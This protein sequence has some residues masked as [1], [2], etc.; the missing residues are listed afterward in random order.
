MADKK[1]NH[2][3]QIDNELY[4]VTAER[5]ANKLI[6]NTVKDGVVTKAG[7]FDG[8][9]QTEVTLAVGDAEAA[10]HADKIQVTMANNVQKYA[11]I[12]IKPEDPS[13]GN[14]GDIWFKY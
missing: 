4:S 9:K 14:V 6:I 2:I 7:E 1:L 5:V 10:D 12:T 8:S 11:T 3:V 13:G